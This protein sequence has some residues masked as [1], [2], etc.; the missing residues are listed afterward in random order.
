MKSPFIRHQINYLTHNILLLLYTGVGE[1]NDDIIIIM[2]IDT[3][4]TDSES[5]KQV[6]TG[7][8]DDTNPNG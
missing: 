2:M 3:T 4:H 1:Q 5:K 6:P 7:S 8:E